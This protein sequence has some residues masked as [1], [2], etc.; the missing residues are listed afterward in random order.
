MTWIYEVWRRIRLLGGRSALDSGL[1]EEIRFH[2]EQQTE[3]NRRAGMGPEDARRQAMVTFG[4]VERV[5]EDTRDEFRVTLLEDSTRDIRYG[6]RA[7]WR[8]PGFTVVSALSIAL[9]I[10][11]VATVFSVVHAVV[12]RPLPFDRP[13][14]LVRL[15]E[16]VPPDVSATGAALRRITD[17]ISVGELH[18]IRHRAQA[19]SHIAAYVNA[20]MTL[21]ETAQ[22]ARV[23]GWRVE[24]DLF[25]M[26]GVQPL[27][28]RVFAKSEAATGADG[29]IIVGHAAWQRHLGGRPDV[30]GRTLTLDNKRYAVVG[31]MPP[32]FEFP[33]EFASRDFW[34]PLVLDVSTAQARDVRVPTVSRLADGVSIEQAAAEVGSLLRAMNGK[35]SAY[36]FV[37]VH[38]EWV[39]PIRAA[40]RA[41]AVAVVLVFLIASVNVSSLLLARTA[42]RRREMAIRTA[43]GG[44]RARLVR[45]LLTESVLVAL[46]G[47]A[48]GI[49]LAF[50]AVRLLRTLAATMPRMDLG[51]LTAFPRL[52]EVVIDLPVLSFTVGV[53]LLTGIAC[54]VAPAV[55]YTRPGDA[56]V[57]RQGV[58][59]T[60][61]PARHWYA[62][63]RDLLVVAQLALAT[64][65]LVGA[66]LLAQSFVSLTR[67][68]VGY[69]PEGVV[70]FQVALPA[71]KYKGLTLEGFAEALVAELATAEGVTAAAYTPLLPMVTLLEHS[72]SFRRVP[73]PPTSQSPPDDDLRGVSHDYFQVMGIDVLAGR[74]LSPHDRAGRPRV[75]VIN[76]AMARQ[77]FPG[78]DTIGKTAYLQ[79]VT[80]PWEIVGVVED[81]RQLG[82]AQHPKPQAFVD[83]RQWPGMAP[84]FRFLQYY[85]V[86][87]NTQVDVIAP[88]IREVVRRLDA[89]AAVYNL[90]PMGALLGNAVSRPRFYAALGAAF[91]GMALLIAATGLYG[92]VAYF[93]AARTRE[94]GIRVALG[95]RREQVMGL[96]LH[97]SAIIT[98]VGIVLGGLGALLVTR[99]LESMLFELSPLDPATFV[100]V[101]LVFGIVAAIATSVPAKRVL[102]VDPLV[103]LRHE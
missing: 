27:Y 100:A 44:G 55:R 80:E 42:T 26:L 21:T 39:E 99:Y 23:E 83:S 14:Q 88:R 4:G 40:L 87:V 47:S 16:T 72:A 98:G 53:A 31:V 52:G 65:L 50:V 36:D 1:D 91:S 77:H 61:S 9:G 68:D 62:G 28:G 22:T 51:M 20:Y 45:L 3:K 49:A 58:G 5:K 82:P 59:S 60:A 32:E 11:S 90:A 12:F 93:V 75:V 48:A 38:D 18:E 74:G 97:R 103:A 85:A 84:G 30:I 67:A 95:A 2:I 79:R 96:V 81:V 92:T 94:I 25:P 43:L 56:D 29:V 41:L 17:S 54:G 33:V 70:T 76:R 24:P 7:L 34:V 35:T 86:R 66:G 46:V 89:N 78:E 13:D 10:G 19:V 15:V 102:S 101:A 6:V 57:L 69:E 63:A 37:R 8:A 73:G 71:G 64:I